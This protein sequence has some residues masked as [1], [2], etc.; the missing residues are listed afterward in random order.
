MNY[1]IYP[2]RLIYFLIIIL[3]ISA[4]GK[5][6]KEA[7]KQVDNQNAK[8]K[9]EK[10]ATEETTIT[11]LFNIR[12]DD[13]KI[14]DLGDKYV[15][16]FSEFA[17]EFSKNIG[18]T[19]EIFK[20]YRKVFEDMLAS[21]ST[22]PPESEIM[23]RSFLAMIYQ[24]EGRLKDAEKCLADGIKKYEKNSMY[25]AYLMAELGMLYKNTN[26]FVEAENTFNEAKGLI[27]DLIKSDPS[28]E[29]YHQVHLQLIIFSDTLAEGKEYYKNFAAENP[30]VK[31]NPQILAA[32]NTFETMK[33]DFSDKKRCMEKIEV[34][35]NDR[36]SHGCV[37]VVF[38]GEQKYGEFLE[39]IGDY[40]ERHPQS[41]AGWFQYG[42]AN[43]EYIND[44]NKAIKAFSKAIELKP[45]YANAYA[46]IAESYNR[47]KNWKKATEI[48]EQAAQL[49]P[50]TFFIYQA[51]QYRYIELVNTNKLDAAL[52]YV[53]E[54]EKDDIYAPC[55]NYIIQ[56]DESKETIE[57]NE[58][59]NQ[60]WSWFDYEVIMLNKMGKKEEAKK[61]CLK[62]LEEMQESVNNNQVCIE[63]IPDWIKRVN[64]RS[65]SVGRTVQDFKPYLHRTSCQDERVKK[66][67]VEYDNLP[68]SEKFVKGRQLLEDA[69][70][71]DPKCYTANQLMAFDLA[72]RPNT[73]DKFGE[74][75]YQKALDEMCDSA[76]Y[77]VSVDDRID[78]FKALGTCYMDQGEYQ[79]AI[80]LYDGILQRTQGE[81]NQYIALYG[82]IDANAAMKNCDVVNMLVPQ[83]E[84]MNPHFPWQILQYINNCRS[85]L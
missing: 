3:F 72:P 6:Q 57:K 70:K 24:D 29:G 26:R 64:E 10:I 15:K 55:N 63:L 83:M 61:K 32:L 74:E 78:N 41:Y 22:I 23:I 12:K 40:V 85:D 43:K 2:Q 14:F 21:N 34:D 77:L 62:Y 38:E 65:G 84:S 8:V 58:L 39:F 76:A 75:F 49:N 56:Q 54:R 73:K 67:L 35:I 80:K 13:V 19:D 9:T 27:R 36:D 82:L 44:Y 31:L 59:C 18:N 11:S 28:N 60:Y 20:K 25:K 47:L 33:N 5:N 68:T 69:L 53:C 66:L 71:L 30:K 1:P 50:N 42:Y 17:N 37:R 79:K 48:M 52:K 7:E 16:L 45:D 51:R 4:C 46:N 81:Y